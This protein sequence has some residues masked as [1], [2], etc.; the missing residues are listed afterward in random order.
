[1]CAKF[2]SDR[3]NPAIQILRVFGCVI[4]FMIHFGQVTY[5]SG[6]LRKFTDFGS[7]GVQ[8]F[9]LI[10]GFL[11]ANTFWEN[12]AVDIK[13]YYI[14]RAIAILPLYYL[15][16]LYFII[17]ETILN[18]FV[19]HIP[20]DELHL[21]WFRYIFVLNGL[22]NIG[23]PYWLN[24][25]GTWTVSVFASFYLVAPWI[26][27]K[28]KTVLSAIFVWVTIFVLTG[29]LRS[30]YSC[31]IV[32]SIHWLFLGNVL[33]VCVQKNVHQQAILVFLG[34]IICSIILNRTTYAYVSVFAIAIL[35]LTTMDNLTLPNKMQKT[36][37][38]L[39]KYSYTLYL[40]H[41]VVFTSLINRLN[42]LDLPTVFVG[43]TAIIGSAFATWFVGTFME[44][45]IQ[46][47]LRQK[48]L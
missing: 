29:Y 36:I 48:F 15:V 7:S 21:G 13:T 46:R 3:R 28:T 24:L 23:A 44:K 27:R 18:Y 43:I 8:L 37:H 10:S 11:A 9:F 38:V 45:P 6:V 47:F 22:L 32:E 40:M 16:I 1:M 39:D 17:T 19:G 5:L 33:Y 14:K 31:Y 42:S 41:G 34:A 35:L 25:G 20:P 4:V 26:L 2:L 12:S 30:I